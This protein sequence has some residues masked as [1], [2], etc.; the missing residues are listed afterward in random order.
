MK[1]K[2]NGMRNEKRVQWNGERVQ[3]MRNEYTG[4][5]NEHSTDKNQDE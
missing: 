3:R 2:Y 1:N 4:M 5:R